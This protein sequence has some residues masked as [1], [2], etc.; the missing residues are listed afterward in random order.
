[1]RKA[2]ASLI[3]SVVIGLLAV[4]TAGV[5]TY[6]WFQANASATISASESS[7]SITVTKPDQLVYEYY[8]YNSN[9]TNGYKTGDSYTAFTGA[10]GAFTL[11]SSTTTTA[12]TSVSNLWPGY[13][14]SFCV[15]VTTDKAFKLTLANSAVTKGVLSSSTGYRYLYTTS[16]TTDD[17]DLA[18]A[19]HIYADISTSNEKATFDNFISGKDTES[20]DLTN[21]Y[22]YSKISAGTISLST[23]LSTLIDQESALESTTYYIYYTVE[24]S[25]DSTTYYREVDKDGVT[26]YVPKADST[27]VKRYFIY[28]PTNGNSNCYAGLSFSISELVLG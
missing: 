8:Y 3:T 13:K 24:F 4:C 11:I 16:T 2:K 25:N 7:T 17:I 18:R 26:Q 28:D 22:E 10:G 23:G 6:A 14:M 19:I 9:S 1:M 21:K 20:A 12:Y 27:S 5:S 15:K